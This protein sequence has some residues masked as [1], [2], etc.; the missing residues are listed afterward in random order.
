M[1]SLSPDRSV[2]EWVGLLFRCKLMRMSA[3]IKHASEYLKRPD[4]SNESIA[5]NHNTENSIS[6][7]LSHGLMV[8]TFAFSCK[9]SPVADIISER[10]SER[11]LKNALG[12]SQVS[13][14]RMD[15]F[16]HEALGHKGFM[17]I[18]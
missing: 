16:F 8:S 11:L 15:T 12:Y 4:R 6:Q 18:P 10:A 5:G 2:V 3:G 17:T 14:I 9:Q 1:F 7:I 13:R